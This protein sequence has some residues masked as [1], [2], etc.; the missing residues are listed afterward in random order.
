MQPTE[1][2]RTTLLIINTTSNGHSNSKEELQVLQVQTPAAQH[3]LH[4]RLLVMHHHHR[5]LELDQVHLRRRLPL[6]VE[7]T[8]L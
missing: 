3:L 4:L 1:D 2:I 6:V 5:L 8:M 7:V